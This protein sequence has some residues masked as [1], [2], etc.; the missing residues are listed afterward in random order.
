[1]SADDSSFSFQVEFREI[2][3]QNK[4]ESEK[5]EKHD[6]L[7]KRKEDGCERCGRE[8]LSFPDKKF[9]DEK[10]NDQEDDNNPKEPRASC[11]WVFHPST[12]F[13]HHFFSSLC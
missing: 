7:K 2:P 1:M 6:Y 3:S 5:K 13:I 8:L 12:L 9:G 10:E 4:K 11:P